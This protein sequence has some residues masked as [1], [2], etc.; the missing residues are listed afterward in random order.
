VETAKFFE[1]I[2]NISYTIAFSFLVPSFSY[3]AARLMQGSSRDNI[4]WELQSELSE[5]KKKEDSLQTRLER[6]HTEELAQQVAIAK[7]EQEVLS[8]KIKQIQKEEKEHDISQ[9]RINFY[10]SAL[11]GL[12]FLVFGLL[13]ATDYLA[14]GATMGGAMSLIFSFGSNWGHMTDVLKVLSLL[15]AMLIIIASSYRFS[16]RPE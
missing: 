3:Y 13:S 2:R 15:L 9:A 5:L 6:K 7:Q 10:V 12:A 8:S 4:S 14:A 1:L 16:K 11:I